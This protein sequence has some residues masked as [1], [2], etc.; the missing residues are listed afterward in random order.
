MS[1][2][3]PYIVTLIGAIALVAYLN[4]NSIKT[5]IQTRFEVVKQKEV[6]NIKSDEPQASA[7]PKTKTAPSDAQAVQPNTE[8]ALPSTETTPNTET[9]MPNV[10]T[11]PVAEHSTLNVKN[12]SNADISATTG[13]IRALLTPNRETTIAST[14]AGRI[15]YLRSNLG[16]AF[17]AGAQLVS[18][19]CTQSIARV[20]IAKATL[21]SAIDEHEAK[22]KMQGL[23]QASDLEVSLAASAT[24]KARAELKLNRAMVAE[25]SIIAPWSGRVAQAHVKN[26]MTVTPGQPLLDI[27]DDGPLKIKL[28]IPS[29]LLSELKVG[30]QFNVTIDETGK[31]YPASISAINSRID[32]V[33]QTVEIQA[34]MKKTHEELLAGMS[35]TADFTSLGIYQ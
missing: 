1:K 33:S 22:V 6:K 32:P 17:N 8:P 14:I 24:N 23:D 29:Q 5:N 34:T 19:D 20:E 26:N 12:T 3:T 13:S 16:Q 4:L 7:P 10:D 25:C 15:K 28:N 30:N 27:V 31:S 2:S 18:F 35:G 21:A 11:S 9:T